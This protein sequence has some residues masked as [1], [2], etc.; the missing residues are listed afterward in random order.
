ME[1]GNVIESESKEGGGLECLVM[2]FET[3]FFRV[4]VVFWEE[5]NKH[6]TERCGKVNFQEK[7]KFWE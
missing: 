7:A 6:V 2:G 3:R 1:R 4:K 5:L